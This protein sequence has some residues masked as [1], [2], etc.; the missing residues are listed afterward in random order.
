MPY[1][2]RRSEEVHK[3][4]EHVGSRIVQG[5]RVFCEA[6]VN[7]RRK[8]LAEDDALMKASP[9][10]MDKETRSRIEQELLHWMT[11]L[12]MCKGDWTYI[13]I[14]SPYPNAFVS[15]LAPR[16]IFVHSSLINRLKVTD[17]ELGMVLGHEISHLLHGHTEKRH[18]KLMYWNMLQ[19]VFLTLLDSSGLLTFFALPF[20][21][22]MQNLMLAANSRE[23]ECE[24][25]VTGLKVAALSCFNTHSGPGVFKKLAKLSG[26]DSEDATP[27]W[28]DTHPMPLDREKTLIEQSKHINCDKVRHCHG[29]LERFKQARTYGTKYNEITAHLTK[30]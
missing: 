3:R 22:R 15:D 17:D 25:D 14:D 24:A 16:K 12:K 30:D 7:S 1:I 29:F 13:V 28:S 6:K 19:L 26:R 8:K 11:K 9:K 20:A 23:H 4:V 2:H 5:A 18:E 10:K 21:N 27:H